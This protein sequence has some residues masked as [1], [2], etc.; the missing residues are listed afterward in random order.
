[1]EKE[2]FNFWQDHSTQYLEM[3][4]S[5]ERRERLEHADGYGKRTG[6]CGDTIEFFLIINKGIIDS[7]TFDTDGCMNTNA[8]ANTIAMLLEGKSVEKAWEI[9][10]Q[11][12]ADYLE[13]L[14]QDEYHCAELAV[15]AMYLALSNYGE[16]SR[17]PWKKAYPKKW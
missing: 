12:L 2:T 16:T 9:T 1:M 11:H 7:I 3:A 10:P 6:E 8:C 13:T 4:L 17:E 14:P 15:G 5:S